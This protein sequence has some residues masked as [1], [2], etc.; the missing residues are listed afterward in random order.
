ME[1]VILGRSKLSVSPVAFG[2]WQLSPRF[3]GEQSK[4]DAISAMHRAF[5]LGIN[6]FDTADAYGDGYAESVLG[7]AIA[8]LARDELIIATKFF[9]HFNPDATR[10]PDLTP[11]HLTQR[12]EASLKRLGIETIDVC[13]LHFYDQLTPLE[14]IARTLEGLRDQGKIKNFGVSNHSV[15][16]FRAQRKFGAYDIVQPAYSLVDTEIENDL[17]PFCQAEDIGVMIYSPMQKGLLTGKYRGAE[18]F[19]DFRGNHPDFQGERFKQLCEA[20]QTLHP[21]AERYGLSLYQLVLAATLM[22]PAIHVAI[23]GIK[24]PQQVA[25]AAGAIG[26]TIE[27][28][29]YFAIRTA[30]SIGKAEKVADAKGSRK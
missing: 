16:Q 1:R 21:I 13:L 4:S 6:F 27:R 20:V 19:D 17:L 26:K 29:D 30:L 7:E 9:N 12:C 23:C 2:T 8:G 15:E 28:D 24:T 14:D 3:W 22:H 18:S 5:E 11:R 25:E 10:F